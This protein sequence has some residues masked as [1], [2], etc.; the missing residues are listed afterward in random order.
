[1]DN[2]NELE[3]DQDKEIYIGKLLLIIAKIAIFGILAGSCALFL[4]K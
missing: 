2:L 4:L 3:R 1:M